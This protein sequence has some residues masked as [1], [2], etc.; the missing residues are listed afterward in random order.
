MYVQDKKSFYIKEEGQSED[1]M[2]LRN[3]LMNANPNLVEAASSSEAEMVFRLCP[4]IFRVKDF[5]LKE[6][7]IDSERNCIINED[8][9]TAVQNYEYSKLLFIYMNQGVFL[10][11]AKRYRN[12][13]ENE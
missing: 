6:I 7:Y 2:Y 12:G 9:V 4:Y 5:S 8:D 13:G 10:E 1:A 3:F 11:A